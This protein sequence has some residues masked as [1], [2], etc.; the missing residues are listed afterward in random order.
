MFGVFNPIRLPLPKLCTDLGW[1]SSTACTLTKINSG[2][3]NSKRRAKGSVDGTAH[4]LEHTRLHVLARDSGN[5]KGGTQGFRQSAVD[6]V[7]Q[8]RNT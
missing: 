8:A 7:H 3:F 4:G 1:L 5:V 6:L 2:F